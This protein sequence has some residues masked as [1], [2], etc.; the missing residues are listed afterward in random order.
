MLSVI[1]PTNNRADLLQLAL[2][3]LQAQTL[4]ADQFEV[5]VIDNG[6]TDNTKQVVESFQQ[7]SV[8]G[9]VRILLS[10]N[11]NSKTKLIT[12]YK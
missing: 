8:E 11:L 5:L 2:L 9:S 7:Q 12:I 6:S 1:I 3:S 10:M 4:P